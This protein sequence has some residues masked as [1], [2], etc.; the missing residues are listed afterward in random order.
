M[1]EKA[2]TSMHCS[3]ALEPAKLIL[4]GTRTTYTKPPGMVQQE[5]HYSIHINSGSQKVPRRQQDVEQA[6]NAY[7]SP[8]V[9]AF[10]LTTLLLAERKQ[11]PS[12]SAIFGQVLTKKN[13]NRIS[14]HGLI[15]CCRRCRYH[16]KIFHG[17]K[18]QI[19]AGPSGFFT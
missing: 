13:G 6:K 8:R 7:L 4:I 18:R 1:Q 9:L 12:Y 11:L 14:S 2:L 3:V 17:D 16:T 5:Y 10:S 15:P 19:N